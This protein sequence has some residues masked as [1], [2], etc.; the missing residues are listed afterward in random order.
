MGGDLLGLLVCNRVTAV[1]SLA[2]SRMKPM[3]S[4]DPG[5]KISLE[6]VLRDESQVGRG[7]DGKAADAVTDRPQGTSAIVRLSNW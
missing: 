7:S 3:G 2:G 6:G 1:M 4:G 5:R